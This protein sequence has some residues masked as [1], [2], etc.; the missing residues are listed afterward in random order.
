MLDGYLGYGAQT[1]DELLRYLTRSVNGV[2]L[3]GEEEQ[4]AAKIITMLRQEIDGLKSAQE[5]AVLDSKPDG[6]SGADEAGTGQLKQEIERLKQEYKKDG[7]RIAY[8]LQEALYSSG[9][10]VCSA[11]G[12]D[13]IEIKKGSYRDAIDSLMGA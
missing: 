1:I 11:D 13:H 4:M 9:D 3:A 10:Y 5:L 7:Q 12:L 8:S 6:V 2:V